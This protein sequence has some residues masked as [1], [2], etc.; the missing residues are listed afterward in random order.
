MIRRTETRSDLEPCKPVGNSSV[1][2]SDPVG[3]EHFFDRDPDPGFNKWP[4][5][6]K[7]FG[8]FKSDKY[9]KGISGAELFG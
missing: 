3:S 1:V 7:L 5:M 4:N 6:Y 2:D 9:T 8:V